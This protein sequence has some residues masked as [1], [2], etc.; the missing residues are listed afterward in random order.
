MNKAFKLIRGWSR[1]FVWG[2]CPECNGDSPRYFDCEVCDK[3]HLKNR[4]KRPDKNMKKD[5]W[6]RYKLNI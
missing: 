2:Y 6:K 4:Y 5:F 3:F 1:L